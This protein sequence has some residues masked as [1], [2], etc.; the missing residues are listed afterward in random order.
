MC[1][2][3][4]TLAISLHFFRLY[5]SS[6]VRRVTCMKDLFQL[7]NFESHGFKLVYLVKN[8][9]ICVWTRPLSWT[10]ACVPNSPLDISSWHVQYWIPFSFSK[11]S[12]TQSLCISVDGNAILLPFH[13]KNLEVIFDSSV[14]YPLSR[15]LE[16][17][18]GSTSE[19][20]QKKTTSHHLHSSHHHLS[21]QY[22]LPKL[23]SSFYTCPWFDSFPTHHSHQIPSHSSQWSRQY[24]PYKR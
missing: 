14:L 11:V 19:Y 6:S 20:I 10:Y 17:S 16:N 4:L 23:L 21:H 8:S 22:L 3:C 12:S 2:M 15:V 5:L 18:V 24:I 13:F 1:Y 7:K 9:Q